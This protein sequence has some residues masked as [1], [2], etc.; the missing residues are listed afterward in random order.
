M[1]NTVVS[2]FKLDNYINFVFDGNKDKIGKYYFK[3]RI[4]II[5]IK[6][7]LKENCKHFVIAIN[8]MHKKFINEIEK[9]L[10]NNKKSVSILFSKKFYLDK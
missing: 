10:F 4:K 8:P 5:D 9:K 1:A 6:D 3:N 2:F 7:I